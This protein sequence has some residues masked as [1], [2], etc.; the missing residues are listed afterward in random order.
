MKRG[1]YNRPFLHIT[2]MG[3]LG[4]G[5]VIA[6]FLAES[7]P[8]FSPNT[9][10]VLAM[11]TAN[12]SKQ[13]ITVDDNVF[14]TNVSTKPRDK[15]ITYTVEPGDTIST[16]A[17]KFSTKDNPIS[18]DTIRWANDLTNDAINP[19]DTLKILPVTG[20]AHKV[21]AGDTVYSIAKKYSL[22]DNNP[23]AIVD[24]PFNPFANTET[25]ALVTGDIIIVP[26]GVPPAQ[27]PLYVD[28]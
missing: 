2:T 22:P 5:V 27:Q 9:Q 21:Q 13:S 20:V 3:V 7:Y 19:G 14:A 10:S 25:F 4:L 11:A 12:S 17:H 23:Q 15:I 24:F 26:G 6:P 16:I 1:R 8:I 18:E 28:A